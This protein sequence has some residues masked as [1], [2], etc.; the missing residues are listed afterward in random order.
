[1][2]TKTMEEYIET[3]YDFERQNG[4]AHTTEIAKALKVSPASVTEMLQ[5]LKDDGYVIYEPYK[6]AALTPKGLEVALELMDRHQTLAEF[7]VIIGVDEE[8]AQKD[9]CQI[10]H[11]V[12][13]ET[14]ERLHMF[15]D[16]VQKAPKDPKWLKHYQE[17]TR[18]GKRPICEEEE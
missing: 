13:G 4:H 9:A 8:T 11:H 1:M 7:L 12:T 16:F 10:E 3:I 15:V 5:K 17:F 2:P 18:T 14:M 6:A